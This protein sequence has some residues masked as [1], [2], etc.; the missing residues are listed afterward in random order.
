M[1]SVGPFGVHTD[2]QS[3]FPELLLDREMLLRTVDAPVALSDL[4]R[5]RVLPL[6][7]KQSLV[8][9]SLQALRIWESGGGMAAAFQTMQLD[10]LSACLRKKFILWAIS[11][12]GESGQD[13]LWWAFCRAVQ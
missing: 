12:C 11:V 13:V 1:A 6:P 9:L 5:V 10:S 3:V 7:L 4:R 2:S 8:M